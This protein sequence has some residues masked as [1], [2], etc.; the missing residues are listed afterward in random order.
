MFW[1]TTLSSVKRCDRSKKQR[2][3]I[4]C[5]AIVDMYN[6]SMGGVEVVDALISY[7]RILIKSKKYYLR[8]FFHLV[9]L[10]VVNAW[11]LCR[12][13]CKSFDVPQNRQ[14]DL[15]AFRVSFADA[16]TNLIDKVSLTQDSTSIRRKQKKWTWSLSCSRRKT[17][18][19]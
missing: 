2:L 5:P 4:N 13:D 18:K 12:R 14:K 16:L 11:L 15:L 1:C 8:V 6:N 7:Y 17:T 19:M 10:C 9:D 3:S